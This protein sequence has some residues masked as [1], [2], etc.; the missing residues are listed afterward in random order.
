L[1]HPANQFLLHQLFDLLL[2]LQG[3]L[4]SNVH[5]DQTIVKLPSTT[6]EWCFL[7]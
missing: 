2:V 6:L 3:M 7:P 4:S 5:L 1:H